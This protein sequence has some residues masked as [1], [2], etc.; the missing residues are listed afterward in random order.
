MPLVQQN[1]LWN[2]LRTSYIPSVAY[3]VR[4]LVYRDEEGVE[5]AEEIRETEVD[6]FPV[7]TSGVRFANHNTSPAQP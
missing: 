5:F 4:M 3:R 7:N 1:E 6:Q 2:A